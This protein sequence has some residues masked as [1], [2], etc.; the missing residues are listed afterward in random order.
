MRA[1]LLFLFAIVSSYS[2]A[3]QG[4]VLFSTRVSE[5]GV[6]IPARLF[7]SGSQIGPGPDFQ[8][9]LFMSDNFRLTPIPGSLTTFRDA[10]SGNPALAQYVIPVVAEVPGI[11]PGGS[12]MLRIRAWHSSFSSY[13]EAHPLWR[14]ETGDFLVSNLGGDGREPAYLANTSQVD[15]FLIVIPEPKASALMALAV[16]AATTNS[17]FSC[18]K[19]HRI[20]AP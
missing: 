9:Q 11:P 18:R 16:L 20:T 8:A 19:P 5:A 1:A 4:T 15:G 6:D 14:G 12:A 10:S 3:A 13:E 2:A 17:L 7:S